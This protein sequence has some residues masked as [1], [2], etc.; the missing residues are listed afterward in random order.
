MGGERYELV[1]EAQRGQVP[2]IIRL[3]HVLK[4]LL[5]AYNFRALSVR[6]VPPKL[7]PLATGT[8][9]IAQDERSAPPTAPDPCEGIP[10]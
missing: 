3:R 4:A 2:P 9:T 10:W 7:P 8:P 5:R 6:D 1:I